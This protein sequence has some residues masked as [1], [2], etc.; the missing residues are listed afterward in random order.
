MYTV[1]F[2][3]CHHATLHLMTLAI[4][5]QKTIDILWMFEILEKKQ[6]SPV[7]KGNLR[8]L[9]IH[10]NLFQHHESC[11]NCWKNHFNLLLLQ[12]TLEKKNEIKKI[13]KDCRLL[14]RF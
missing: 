9:A 1:S 14:Q 11:T 8:R 7:I 5:T 2:Y 10:Y 4:M 3:K 13:E 12:V 6:H